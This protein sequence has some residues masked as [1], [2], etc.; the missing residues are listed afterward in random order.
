MDKFFEIFKMLLNEPEKIKAN[1]ISVIKL[2]LTLVFAEW[3]Y[4]YFIGLYHLI[5]FLSLT[6]WIEFILKGRVFVCILTFCVSYILLFYLLPMISA[7]PF[8]MLAKAMKLPNGLDKNDSGVIR[9]VLR[10]FQLLDINEKEGRLVVMKNT[11]ILRD[12]VRAFSEKESKKEARLLKDT[13]MSEI[14]HTYFVFCVLYFLIFKSFS[15]VHYLNTIV[16]TGF[17]LIVLFYASA[18]I[19]IDLMHKISKDLIFIIDWAY[20]EESMIETMKEAGFFLRASEQKFKGIWQ[21]SYEEKKYVIKCN[22]DKRPI[23]DRMIKHCAEIA[24]EANAKFIILSSVVVLESA[25]KAQ[26]ENLDSVMVKYFEDEADL[27]NI[28]KKIIANE[29]NEKKLLDR[30]N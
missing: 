3:L 7:L 4:R 30:N 25:L 1:I 15:S 27:I 29:F 23:N 17:V 26:N 5:N 8:W 12:I 13:L 28:I 14:G 16:I 9:W 10:T 18:S 21:F 22:I 11:D 6:E 20:Y 24:K 2:F 19:F